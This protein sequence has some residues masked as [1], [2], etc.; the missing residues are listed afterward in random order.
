MLAANF[1]RNEL[2][3][4]TPV[5][6]AEMQLEQTDQELDWAHIFIGEHSFEVQGDGDNDGLFAFSRARLALGLVVVLFPINYLALPATIA[7]SFTFAAKTSSLV[8]AH[9]TRERSGISLHA[10][11]V[12]CAGTSFVNIKA[13]VGNTKRQFIPWTT[14]YY[15]LLSRKWTTMY[16]GSSRLPE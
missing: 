14:M 15:P 16:L 3:A 12:A 8:P 9:A 5:G 10:V 4:A 13:L 6:G 1:T 7:C 2:K 11:F